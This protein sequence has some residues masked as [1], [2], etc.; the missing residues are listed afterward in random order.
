MFLSLI[1]TGDSCP[2]N[3]T[4]V[5]TIYGVAGTIRLLAGG[6]CNS[7]L[8]KYLIRIREYY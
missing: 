6:S 3:P 8:T 1:V 2:G 5:Q 4:K 7:N